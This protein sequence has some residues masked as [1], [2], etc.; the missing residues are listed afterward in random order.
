[1]AEYTV[2]YYD[3]TEKW[4]E[5]ISSAQPMTCLEAVQTALGQHGK[6]EEPQPGLIYVC[7][8]SQLLG[9]TVLPEGAHLNVY[10]ILGGG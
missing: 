4:T 7:D 9:N 8:G 5:T 3:L 2:V 10:M 1:M 6:S